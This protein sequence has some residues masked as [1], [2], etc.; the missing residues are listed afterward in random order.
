MLLSEGKEEAARPKLAAAKEGL[1][2][3]I[4]RGSAKWLNDAVAALENS[5]T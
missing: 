3:S 1:A 2:R 4:D 5:Y